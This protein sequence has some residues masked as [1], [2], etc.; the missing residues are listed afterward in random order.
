[1]DGLYGIMN[2]RLLFALALCLLGNN[3]VFAQDDSAKKTTSKQPWME[4][5]E[6][7]PPK[8]A[9]PNPVLKMLIT[10]ENGSPVPKE[11]VEDQPLTF[12][13]ISDI[14]FDTPP[15]NSVTS[16][17]VFENSQWLMPKPQVM[18]YLKDWGS[19]SRTSKMIKSQE[20]LAPNVMVVIPE[21]P[22][23]DGAISC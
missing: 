11:I 20:G 21:N 8:P 7:R 15:T 13:A 17:V 10:D 12:T 9:I 4:G 22:C 1:M 3:L 18:W 6:H 14:F 5:A 2:K 16:D 23:D 19:S